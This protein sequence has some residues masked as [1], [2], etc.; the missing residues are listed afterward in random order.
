MAKTPTLESLQKRIAVLE[1]TLREKNQEIEQARRSGLSKEEKTK[2]SFFNNLSDN[3]AVWASRGKE[4]NYEI[5]FWNKSAENIYGH[6][7]ENAMSK[8]FLKLFISDAQRE[9]AQD[10]CDIII[11]TGTAYRNNIATDYNSK[12]KLITLI[13]NTF[14]IEDYEREGKYLQGEIGLDVSDLPQFKGH[15]S[16]GQLDSKFELQQNL[17]NAVFMIDKEAV[18]ERE[19]HIELFSK[20]VINCA[21]AIFGKDQLYLIHWTSNSELS[22]LQNSFSNK[23]V[24]GSEFMTNKINRYK[25]EIHI[26]IKTKQPECRLTTTT[27]RNAFCPIY[28]DIAHNIPL[29]YFLIEFNDDFQI[30]EDIE[31]AVDVFVSQV[32][33]AL[34]YIVLN[35]LYENVTNDETND[36]S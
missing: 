19:N 16:L 22:I 21:E 2:L 24:E 29:G 12:R 7:K 31:F 15:R 11:Q 14:R 17:I 27:T 5:V 1:E 20:S 28:A 32:H 36:E 9:A 25:E 3:I 13:T 30:S 4:D 6:T 26:R 35:I 8:N 33:F 10:D 34:K 18:I 23:L